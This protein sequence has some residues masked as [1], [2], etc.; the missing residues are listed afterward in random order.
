MKTLEEIIPDFSVWPKSWMGGARDVPYGQ[1]ILE[2]FRP[3]I[4]TLLASGVSVKTIKRHVDNLWLLG[5]EIIRDA[6]INKDYAH[7]SPLE[8]LREAVGLDGGPYCQHLS[9]EAEMASFDATCRKLHR[10]LASIPE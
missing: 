8:S 1:G 6:H 5:G 3:F 2:V 9:S 10:F 7:I 4:Q